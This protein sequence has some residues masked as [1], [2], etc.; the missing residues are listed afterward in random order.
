MRQKS[1]ALII[2]QNIFNTSQIST[3]KPRGRGEGM[4]KQEH[5]YQERACNI[6]YILNNIGRLTNEQLGEE[7]GIDGREVYPEDDACNGYE[8]I[9]YIDDPA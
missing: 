4:D 7:C 5:D 9:E 6:K 2:L 1:T 3:A 8:E